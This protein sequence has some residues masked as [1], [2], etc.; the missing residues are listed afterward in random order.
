MKIVAI[1]I[2]ILGS[3]GLFDGVLTMNEISMIEGVLFFNLS[4]VCFNI[5]L[6]NSIIELNKKVTK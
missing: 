1:I 6:S 3:I 2:A 5:S 4:L